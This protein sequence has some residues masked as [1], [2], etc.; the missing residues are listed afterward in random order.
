MQNGFVDKDPFMTL[1]Y[2]T[3]EYAQALENNL[4]DGFTLYKYATMDKQSR[5]EIA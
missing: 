3:K 1:P 4:P 5:L 2:M